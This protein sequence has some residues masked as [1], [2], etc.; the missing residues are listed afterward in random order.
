MKEKIIGVIKQNSKDYILS[1]YPKER[2]PRN[3]FY[4]TKEIW[5]AFGFRHEELSK[6]ISKELGVRNNDTIKE[7]VMDSVSSKTYTGFLK[8]LKNDLIRRG[9]LK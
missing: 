8:E 7:Y 6:L 3:V 1:V 9:I 5:D 4:E 2:K